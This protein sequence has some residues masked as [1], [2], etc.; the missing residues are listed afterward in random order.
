MG[1]RV[2]TTRLHLLCESAATSH[3]ATA[4]SHAM[5]A[6][7]CG[8]GCW[9]LLV[10]SVLCVYTWLQLLLPK[11]AKVERE[12]V[13]WFSL[14]YPRTQQPDWPAAR[15]LNIIQRPGE[16]VFVPHGWW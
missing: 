16:T 4:H 13:S 1:V 12:A 10:L 6:S 9:L 8:A 14:I 11:E 15:P 2:C 3:R 5:S 7:H